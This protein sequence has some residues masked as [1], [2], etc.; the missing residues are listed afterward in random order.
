MT[1]A[2]RLP[3]WR[4]RRS[5]A[6]TPAC[7]SALQP[8]AH[9]NCASRSIH[10]ARS[11]KRRPGAGAR[12]ALRLS[13]LPVPDRHLGRSASRSASAAGRPKARGKPASPR[14]AAVA[15]C[16][17]RPRCQDDRGSPLPAAVK[18]RPPLPHLPTLRSLPG[19]S[20]AGQHAPFPGIPRLRQAHV[21]PRPF[22]PLGCPGRRRH[23][24]RPL[25]RLSP[26]GS[27]IAL[28]TL[29]SAP[30]PALQTQL[31]ACAGHSCAFCAR[32]S[33][34]ALEPARGAHTRCEAG[35]GPPACSRLP[36]CIAYSH[37]TGH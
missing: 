12:V 8:P 14:W 35:L 5:S 22:A 24:R 10:R 36:S 32:A 4:Q 34:P 7:P 25:C 13:G 3:G 37:T 27:S 11:A 9:H 20:S 1:A 33:S 23:R 2:C 26:P 19:R 6:I 18:P 17:A 15:G 30:C 28:S 16:W 21:S 31:G 29:R